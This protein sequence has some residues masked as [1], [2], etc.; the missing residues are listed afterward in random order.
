MAASKV[1]CIEI[2]D[3][4]TRVVE[5]DNG[6]KDPVIHKA[7]V[8]NIGYRNLTAD[9]LVAGKCNNSF[10]CVNAGIFQLIGKFL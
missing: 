4:V 10:L 9:N 2:T 1:V 8:L 5:M 7:I 3:V 6:K